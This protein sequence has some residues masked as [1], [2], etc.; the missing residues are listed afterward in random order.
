MKRSFLLI[1]LLLLFTTEPFHAQT[2]TPKS[3][4]STNT[5]KQTHAKAAPDED[6]TNPEAKSLY[7]DGIERLDMGQ[8]SESVERFQKALKLDPVYAPAYSALGRAFFKLRQ[9]ENA[10]EAFR[11]AI[12]LKAKKGESQN[13][14]QKNQTHKILH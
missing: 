13:N 12:A 1:V 10:S 6:E 11:R 4:P 14:P 3:E 7:K 2:G 9:W 8:V 5:S